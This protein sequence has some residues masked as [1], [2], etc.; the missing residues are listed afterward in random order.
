LLNISFGLVVAIGIAFILAVPRI[1]TVST[2]KIGL[3]VIGLAIFVL[4]GRHGPRSA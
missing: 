4:A 1:G 2:W 3:G